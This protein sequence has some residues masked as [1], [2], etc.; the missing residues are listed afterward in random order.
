MTPPAPIAPA[1]ASGAAA[2][3]G[4]RPPA[5]AAP[6]EALKTC[7]KCKRTLNLSEFY[8]D[9]GKRDGRSHW[10][11]ACNRAN[12]KAAVERRRAEIGEEAWR[13]ERRDA[14]RRHRA[15][16]GTRD[17]TQVKAYNAAMAQIRERHR[18]EFDRL[19]AIELRRQEER[20]A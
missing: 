6:I 5:V 4:S 14:V 9:K 20:A 7:T 10:C 8:R 1:P 3:A 15:K 16:N 18:K 12:T 13:A 17:K 19:Y 2:T 11:R